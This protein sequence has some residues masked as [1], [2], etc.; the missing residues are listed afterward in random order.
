MSNSLILS[1]FMLSLFA[2]RLPAQT[3]LWNGVRTT[4]SFSETP[5][6]LRLTQADAVKALLKAPSQ[7]DPWQSCI[8]DASWVEGVKFGSIGLSPTHKTVLVEAGVGCARGGQGANGAMWIVQLDG[9]HPKILASP[10]QDF[11]GWPFSVQPGTSHGYSDVVL[12]WHVSVGK[13]GLSYFRFDGRSYRIIG[14][15]S[16][17]TDDKGDLRIVPES[18][19]SS[20]H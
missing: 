3:D 10:I 1:L 19:A 7:K 13:A 6:T 15:A 5:I 14:R 18:R 12:G 20:T 2:A 11:S 16:L 9:K 4:R 8:D 17:L